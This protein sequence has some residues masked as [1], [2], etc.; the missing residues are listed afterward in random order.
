M[1][2]KPDHFYRQSGVVAYDWDDGELQVLLITSSS[3]KR[4]VIPKG[5]VEPGLTP[6]ESALKEAHEEAGISGKGLTESLGHYQYQ[7]WGG[8]CDV[9]VFPLEVDTVL[10]DWP[11]A[12]VRRR[13]WFSPAGA[14]DNVREPALQQILRDLATSLS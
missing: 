9:T 1:R 14:A 13:E 2:A 12:A 5:I 8:V 7:K 3:G 4:W 11:E 6:L 10:A